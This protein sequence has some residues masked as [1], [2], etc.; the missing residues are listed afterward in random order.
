MSDRLRSRWGRRLPFL[1]GGAVLLPLATF[2]LFNL[3][4]MTGGGGV[5]LLVLVLAL[6]GAGF[7]LWTVPFIAV[8]AEMTDDYHE[9]SVVMSCRSYGNAVGIMLGSS[10]PAWLLVSWGG[11]RPGHARMGLTI[12]LIG[13][14][15][16]LLS[17]VMLRRA[18][19]TTVPVGPRHSLLQQARFVWGNMPFRAIAGA[20]VVFLFGVATVS[21]TNAFFSR[22]VLQKTDVW[23]GTFY[24]VLLVGNL[25]ATPA[26]LWLSRRIDKRAAYTWSM[27]AYGLLHLTWL[28]ARP[29]EPMPI[30]V[31][32]VFLIGCAMSGVILV[33][34]SLLAD[35]IRYDFIRSGA[36]QEGAFSSVNGVIERASHALGIAAIGLVLG[37]VGYRPSMHGPVHQA[38]PVIWGL[39]TTFSIIPA[40]TA[41]LSLIFMRFYRLDEQQLR[42]G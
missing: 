1:L 22:Y 38:A 7:I 15:C 27:S 29:G 14:A 36:R 26:W 23:L 40:A 28:L 4:R 37:A 2:L 17:V 13:L 34:Y 6:Y 21:G 12:A 10:L 33:G 5:P 41:L 39:F 25:L 30:L 19:A 11:G 18:P 9:R 35:A 20:Q 42:G 8:G 24:I 16:G 32:R 3:P 31:G